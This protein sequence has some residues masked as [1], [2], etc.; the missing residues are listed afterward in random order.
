MKKGTAVTVLNMK[1]DKNVVV[2][3]KFSVTHKYKFAACDN[4]SLFLL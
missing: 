4:I 3:V 1:C 2:S